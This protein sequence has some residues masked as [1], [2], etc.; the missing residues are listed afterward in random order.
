MPIAV[1]TAENHREA[2]RA[3]AITP[4]ASATSPSSLAVNG[5]VSG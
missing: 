4:M 1:P 5:S 2:D 3:S